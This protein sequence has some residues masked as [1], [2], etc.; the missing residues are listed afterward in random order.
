MSAEAEAN[1]SAS[2]NG[3]ANANACADAARRRRPRVW[4]LVVAVILGGLVTPLLARALSPRLAAGLT[5]CDGFTLTTWSPQAPGQLAGWTRGHDAWSNPVRIEEVDPAAAPRPRRGGRLLSDALVV[6]SFGPDGLD[7]QGAGDDLVLT[8][9]ELTL[10][11]ALHTAP[12]LG[13]LLAAALA[14]CLSGPFTHRPRAPSAL[15]E[16]RR[17]LGLA[18]LPAL[19][20]LG[21]GRIAASG[22]DRIFGDPLARLL[23]SRAMPALL[24]SPGWAFV[25]AYAAIAFALAFAWRATRPVDAPA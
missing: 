4:T 1:G 8:D 9:V 7:D 11:A 13:V 15:P 5:V 19:L 3:S 23:E 6:R 17:A 12:L 18:G 22:P 2:A 10:A 21:A 16:V 24:V 20:V 14:W 25:L